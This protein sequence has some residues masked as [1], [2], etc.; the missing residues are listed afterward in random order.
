MPPKST[1][2]WTE[3][4]TAL[5]GKPDTLHGDYAGAIQAVDA[6]MTQRLG[7]VNALPFP[8]GK[9][10]S[11]RVLHKGGDWGYVEEKIRGEKIS[12]KFAFCPVDSEE[13]EAWKNFLETGKLQVPSVDAEPQSYVAGDFWLDKLENIAEKS[14]FSLLHLGVVRYA[15]G[16]VAGAKKAWEESLQMQPSAWAYRNISMLYKSELGDMAK[17]RE[18]ILKAFELKKDNPTLCK[19][20]AMQLTADGGDTLWLQIYE[21]LADELKALGRMRL[22]KAIA[23]INLDRLEEA[24]QI[25]NENF[26]LN[27]IKEGELSV[28][29]Y[30]FRLY[31][32]LYAKENGLAYDEQDKALAQAADAKYPLPKKLDF[33]MH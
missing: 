1:W 3:A 15:K 11:T 8:S 21:T 7:D 2:A 14:W 31:R 17:A 12:D 6:Y 22:Y 33:R 4:Y 25:I 24:A 16:D 27:D 10:L 19:E 28:S 32:G 30:W 18:L 29:Y 23:L 26:V 5:Q 9:T 13:T 20:V